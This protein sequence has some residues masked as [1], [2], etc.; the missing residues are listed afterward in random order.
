MSRVEPRFNPVTLSPDPRLL[1]IKPMWQD[2]E[3]CWP[4]W[5]EMHEEMLQLLGLR[6]RSYE[7]DPGIPSVAVSAKREMVDRILKERA[8][9][10]AKRASDALSRPS[11]VADPSSS[12]ALPVPASSNTARTGLAFRRRKE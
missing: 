12:S 1:D 11:R 4:W 10:Y 6:A 5:A 8:Q 9:C 2:P 7:R 3:D